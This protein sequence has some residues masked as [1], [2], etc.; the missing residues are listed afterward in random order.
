MVMGYTLG[1]AKVVEGKPQE[2]EWIFFG[3]GG[4]ILLH[5]AYDFFIVLKSY[6]FF[7][8]P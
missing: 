1:R 6:Y 8:P 4:A 5:G 3:L 2:R 7:S